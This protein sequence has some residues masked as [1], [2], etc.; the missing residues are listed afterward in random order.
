MYNIIRRCWFAVEGDERAI[1]LTA[2]TL[3]LA[4]IDWSV[5]GNGTASR[6]LERPTIA[7]D[8]DQVW[9]DDVQDRRSET[10]TNPPVC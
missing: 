10:I 6:K 8:K 7:L 5:A 4:I 2:R 1:P 3:R 9:T